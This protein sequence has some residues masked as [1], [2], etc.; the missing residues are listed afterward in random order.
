MDL[1]IAT[2]TAGGQP[3]E[4]DSEGPA[5]WKP[6]P[7]G[8]CDLV[9]TVTDTAGNWTQPLPETPTVARSDPALPVVSLPAPADRAALIRDPTGRETTLTHGEQGRRLTGN[10]LRNRPSRT[11]P[12]PSGGQVLHVSFEDVVTESVDD[13]KATGAGRLGE[14]RFHDNLTQYADGRAH[15]ASFGGMPTAGFAATEGASR[16]PRAES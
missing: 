5:R 8:T 16:R 9:I 6:P 4:V 7:V 15:P 2:L 14:R 3:R 11:G 12:T 1:K 13:N 10:L